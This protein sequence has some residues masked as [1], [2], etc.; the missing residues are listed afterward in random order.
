M[1]T[2]RR[3]TDGSTGHRLCAPKAVCMAVM[4]TLLCH[5]CDLPVEIRRGRSVYSTLCSVVVLEYRDPVQDQAKH[6][7]SWLTRHVQVR[8]AC[9]NSHSRQQSGSFTAISGHSWSVATLRQDDRIR[10]AIS[11]HTLCW[12]AYLGY[13]KWPTPYFTCRPLITIAG[14][15]KLKRGLLFFQSCPC[16]G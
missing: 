4:C 5:L 15:T 2:C 12:V 9:P 13:L 11:G 7:L 10:T 8:Q 3:I 6:V 1:P 16:P 14:H